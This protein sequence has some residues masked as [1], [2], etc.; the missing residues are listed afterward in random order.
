MIAYVLFLPATILNFFIVGYKYSF[1]GIRG[2]FKDSAKRIDI[3][4]AGEFRT[5]WNVLLIKKD[6]IKF[7]K[8]G[9]TISYYLG[10]NQHINTLSGFGKLIVLILD[11][12]DK[13]HCKK[14]FLKESK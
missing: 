13:D 10:A 5:L 9:R 14:A 1:S 8:T 11:S 12:I 7:R 3:Y 6:G 4:A 2:Y